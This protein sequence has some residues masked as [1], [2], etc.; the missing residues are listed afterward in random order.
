MFFQAG[1]KPQHEH[2]RSDGSVVTPETDTAT[3]AASKTATESFPCHSAASPSLMYFTERITAKAEVIEIGRNSLEI[4]RRITVN[5][6]LSSNSR[7]SSREVC[8]DTKSIASALAKE[9][10]ANADIRWSRATSY[11]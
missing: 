4:Q 7:F 10:D 3:A 8:F 2:Y 9:N 11:L 5:A 6:S 1:G